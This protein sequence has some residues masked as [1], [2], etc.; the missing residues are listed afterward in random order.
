MATPAHP[1]R[2]SGDGL[3]YINPAP[4]DMS[5]I[6]EGK[7]GFYIMT[8]VQGTS[9]KSWLVDNEELAKQLCEKTTMK[10]LVDDRNVIVGI[11]E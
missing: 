9:V 8:L 6:K 4:G 10:L 2:L 7:N 11:A 5:A 3:E 1:L